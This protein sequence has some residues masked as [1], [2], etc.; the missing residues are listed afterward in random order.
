MHALVFD[1]T[2]P[3]LDEA[4][5]ELREQVVPMVRQAPGFVTGVWLESGEGRGQ[6]VVVFENEDAA[7]TAAQMARSTPP[8]AVTL[9]D[10]S[11]REVFAQA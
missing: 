6:A 7:N 9:S 4:L 3:D 5:R 11:V 1:V 8:A 2:I 10:I